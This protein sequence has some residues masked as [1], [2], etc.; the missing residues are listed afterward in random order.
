MLRD[1]TGDPKFVPHAV[2]E[3]AL[4]IKADLS[5]PAEEA[6]LW[7]L[8]YLP[9]VWKLLRKKNVKKNGSRKYLYAP[10]QI[11]DEAFELCLGG[12][13]WMAFEVARKPHLS[14]T[15]KDWDA[16]MQM[17]EA[18]VSML[19]KDHQMF[20]A[21]AIETLSDGST[22]VVAPAEKIASLSLALAE[23]W[24]FLLKEG[25]RPHIIK[26]E[27]TASTD[28]RALDLGLHLV[29]ICEHCF[30]QPVYF[31]AASFTNAAINEGNLITEH[32]LRMA[33]KRERA[34]RPD[35][36]IVKT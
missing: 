10:S 4:A 7:R 28:R 18:K 34:K 16:Q 1:V 17:I 32:A 24:A 35:L 2:M 23:A 26:Q 12:F 36:R 25:P 9:P 22:H 19:L 13:L 11:V 6:L 30:D 21:A 29:R 3:R 33:H 8:V 5:D 14:V 20:S 15:A 27:S 31:V